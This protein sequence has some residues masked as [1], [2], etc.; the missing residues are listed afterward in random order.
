MAGVWKEARLLCYREKIKVSLHGKENARG[1]HWDWG[2]CASACRWAQN[3]LRPGGNRGGGRCR[4]GPVEGFLREV[5]SSQR[6]QRRA[7]DVKE[8]AAGIGAC[9]HAAGASL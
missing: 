3:A 5:S 6:L 2:D 8:G 7:C 4:P 9:L 1:H